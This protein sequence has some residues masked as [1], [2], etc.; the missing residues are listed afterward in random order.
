MGWLKDAWEILRS[1][2]SIRPMIAATLVF[3]AVIVLPRSI[4]EA[5]RLYP[6]I[7]KWW[8]WIVLVFAFSI[9]MILIHAVEAGARPII[10][11]HRMKKRLDSMTDD[12]R[13]IIGRFRGP[14]QNA[15]TMMMWPHEGGVGTL[16]A[17]GVLFQAS[18]NLDNPN[19]MAAFGLTPA[20]RKF[21]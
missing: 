13:G 9:V 15:N 3:G 18:A 14:N 20:A 5:M 1:K 4:L 16:L 21:I 8:P 11:A 10:A 12:E 19:G 2:T 6:T 17:D 7:E